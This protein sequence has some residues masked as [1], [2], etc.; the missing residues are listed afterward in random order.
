MSQNRAQKLIIRM[1][2]LEFAI[3]SSFFYNIVFDKEPVLFAMLEPGVVL[4]Q[5]RKIQGVKHHYLQKRRLE[6]ATSSVQV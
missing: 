4:K 2:H 6:E 1:R 3:T 5:F